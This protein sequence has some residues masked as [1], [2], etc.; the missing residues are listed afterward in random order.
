MNTDRYEWNNPDGNLQV[1]LDRVSTD[2]N[3]ASWIQQQV[4]RQREID[5]PVLDIG[6][7]GGGLY[8]LRIRDFP[9]Y[10]SIAKFFG[11]MPDWKEGIMRGSFRHVL[12]FKWKGSTVMLYKTWPLIT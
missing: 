11:L 3:Y 6:R 1:Y 8:R 7:E 4:Q 12:H 10:Q 5:N 9:H 2:D